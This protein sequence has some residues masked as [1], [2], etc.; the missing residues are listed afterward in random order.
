MSISLHSEWGV[1]AFST[2]RYAA[3]R[4]FKQDASG[5]LNFL[6]FTIA[7]LMPRR[8]IK[9]YIPHPD[10]L[11]QFRSMG[12]FGEIVF[13]PN[14][15]HLNRRSFSGAFGVGMFAALL[16]IPFQMLVSAA[17]AIIFRVNLP[18]SVALVWLTNPLTMPPIFIAQYWIGST[19]LN[20]PM[21]PVEFE[22]SWEW[23]KSGFLQIWQPFLLGSLVVAILGSVSGYFGA[24]F[25]WRF[26]IVRRWQKRKLQRPLRKNNDDNAST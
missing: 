5:I 4:L 3:Q 14:L 10:K 23:A 18:V 21:L 11:R 2:Q 8:L 1:S 25:F 20:T 17:G 6:G 24:K 16:P 19:L 7:N 26:V 22:I 9:K 15:W 12:I 13:E